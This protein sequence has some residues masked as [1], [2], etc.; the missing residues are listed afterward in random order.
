ML[1]GELKT[2]VQCCMAKHIRGFLEHWKAQHTLIHE[3]LKCI[4]L[5]FMKHW[6]TEE[7]PGILE[8]I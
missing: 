8:G 7:C 2:N 6:T 5:C 3:A 4:K 1:R